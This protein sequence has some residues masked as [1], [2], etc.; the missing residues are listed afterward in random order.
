[1]GKLLALGVL[2]TVGIQAAINLIVVTGVGPTKGIA[3]PLVSAGGSGWILTAASL[4]LLMA[5]DRA[6]A[7]ED[8]YIPA[9]ADPAE[10]NPSVPLI[11]S[12]AAQAAV[13]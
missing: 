10:F 8:Q 5:L 4:G 1:V 11:P 12:P 9:P 13:P 3:L 7:R 2:L 6:H